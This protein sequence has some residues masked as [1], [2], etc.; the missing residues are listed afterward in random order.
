MKKA[1][2]ADADCDRGLSVGAFA[3]IMLGAFLVVAACALVG[4]WVGL[5]G[6]VVTAVVLIG[7]SVTRL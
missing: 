1:R 2:A 4:G 3:A 7:F 5:I 6:I